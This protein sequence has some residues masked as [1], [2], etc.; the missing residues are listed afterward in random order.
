MISNGIGTIL[1]NCTRLSDEFDANGSVVLV[2]HEPGPSN[3]V[4]RPIVVA[5]YNIPSEELK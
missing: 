4:E 2:N 3:K 1:G 5:E